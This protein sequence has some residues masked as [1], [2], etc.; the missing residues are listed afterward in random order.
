VSEHSGVRQQIKVVLQRGRAAR[1][2]KLAQHL[3]VRENL[4]RMRAPRFKQ[5]S[6]K[7]RFVYAGEQ[8][9]VSCDGGFNQRVAAEARPSGWLLYLRDSPRGSGQRSRDHLKE[10][11]RLLQA[12][13]DLRGMGT[14]ASLFT[15]L[16]LLIIVSNFIHTYGY[17]ERRC[18]RA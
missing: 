4:P 1:V 10:A 5:A 13:E 3:G 15:H 17:S 6:Q 7:H 8:E 12:A 18:G 16:C 14:N 9:N 11:S 2:L